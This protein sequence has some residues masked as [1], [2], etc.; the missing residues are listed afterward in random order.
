[1]HN[2]H[3]IQYLPCEIV[4]VDETVTLDSDAR[5][6]H[7]ALCITVNVADALMEGSWQGG[8][9]KDTPDKRPLLAGK[10]TTVL[11]AFKNRQ[12]MLFTKI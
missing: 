12:Q 6:C 9:G 1:M 4:S 10:T 11:C 8:A 2:L 5:L 7:N 3:S